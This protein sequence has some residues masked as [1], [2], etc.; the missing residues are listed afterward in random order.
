MCKSM[1]LEAGF[2]QNAPSA[3]TLSDWKRVGLLLNFNLMLSIMFAPVVEKFFCPMLKKAPLLIE[4]SEAS[5]DC[6]WQED[7]VSTVTNAS[8]V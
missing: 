4:S 5:M 1:K 6:Q 3:F 7:L 8:L 2:L